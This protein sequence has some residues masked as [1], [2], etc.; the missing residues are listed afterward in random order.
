M[1]EGMMYFMNYDYRIKLKEKLIS[2]LSIA[3]VLFDKKMIDE[4]EFKRVSERVSKDPQYSDYVE[5]ASDI[6][7]TQL[8]LIIEA[9]IE[10]HGDYKNG[11]ITFNPTDKYG[12][13]FCDLVLLS[14]NNIHAIKIVS[15]ECDFVE[16]AESKEMMHIGYKVVDKFLSQTS[17]DTIDLTVVQPNLLISTGCRVKI[18]SL[19]DK[20]DNRLLQ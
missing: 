6:A 19:L 4:E 13:I 12:N 5:K 10:E 11:R 8:A 2:E 15:M 14:K 9:E 7:W 18:D 20:F 16:P 3:K 17:S 1:V